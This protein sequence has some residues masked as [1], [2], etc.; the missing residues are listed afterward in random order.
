MRRLVTFDGAGFYQ[1]H[2]D[3]YSLFTIKIS[4]VSSLSS[5]CKKLSR[6]T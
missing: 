5:D 3:E 1:L 2:P 4:I 6:A